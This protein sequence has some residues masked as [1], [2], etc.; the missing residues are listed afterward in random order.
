LDYYNSIL[1]SVSRQLPQKLQVVQNAAAR[2]VTGA[3]CRKC[4]LMTPVL[5]E[6]H[7][8]SYQFDGGSHSREQFWHTSVNMVRLRNT[9]NRTV[10]RRQRILATVTRSAQTRQLGVPRT[11]TKMATEAMPSKV[12]VSG[13][14]YLLSCELQT[15]HRLYSEINCK[16][17]CSTSRN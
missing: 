17:I 1:A 16:L 7:W 6:L 10:C 3:T 11:R 9:C 12:L 13:T 4:E 2:L 8:L 15:F 14:V 5:R